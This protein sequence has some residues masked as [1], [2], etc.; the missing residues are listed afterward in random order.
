MILLTMAVLDWT[1]VRQQDV[2][3][4]NLPTAPHVTETNKRDR[5]A[6]AI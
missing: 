6:S 5:Y 4:P 1:N 3:C 2:V